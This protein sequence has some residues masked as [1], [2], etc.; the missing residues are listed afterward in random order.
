MKLAN[1]QVLLAL[2]FVFTVARGLEYHLTWLFLALASF[3]VL[4]ADFN[5]WSPPAPVACLLSRWPGLI[6][7]AL[8]FL[9]AVSV[10]CRRGIRPFCA[11]FGGLL[12]RILPL[13]GQLGRLSNIQVV[14]RLKWLKGLRQAYACL[15]GRVMLADALAEALLAREK[16]MA[17]QHEGEEEEVPRAS[18]MKEALRNLLAVLKTQEVPTRVRADRDSFKR[19]AI[20]QHDW[21]VILAPYQH[22]GTIW[23]SE[24]GYRW[25][26]PKAVGP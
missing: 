16:L 1:L 24:D 23:T 3:L 21:N 13:L 26:D 4:V 20:P 17:I 9:V 6:K 22:D 15:E 12:A 11:Y 18:V 7:V 10:K 5:E 19:L 8:P 25:V 14:M 2:H